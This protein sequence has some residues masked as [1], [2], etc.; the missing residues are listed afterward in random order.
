MGLRPKSRQGILPW[1]PW[2]GG[3]VTLL[4]AAP[5]GAASYAIGQ[6]GAGAEGV[7]GAATA[8]QDLPEV[9]WFNPAAQP[10]GLVLSIGAS[11]IFPRVEHTA[12][13]GT[14]T[15]SESAP[16]TPPWAHLGYVLQHDEQRFG[17]FVTGHVP[18]GAGLQWPETWTGRFEVTAVSLRVYEAAANAVY[19]ITLNDDV[20]LGVGGLQ[21]LFGVAGRSVLGGLRHLERFGA[22]RLGPGAIGLLGLVGVGAGA[23]GGVE[24]VRYP[25]VACLH[26]AAD[27]AEHPPADHE[28]D[29]TEGDDQPEQL[30][31]EGGVNLG[32]LRHLALRPLLSLL[33]DEKQDH[34][35][36][37]RQ[38]AEKLGCGEADEQA[39]LLAIGGGRIAKRALEERA[40]HVTN[41]QCGHAHA[42]RGETSTQQFCCF[43]VHD[44][45]SFC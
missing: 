39:A 26:G 16:A 34:G 30:R 35:D 23:L 22:V 36:D 41:A 37:E 32:N 15:G 11:A 21:L 10:A 5:A 7:A 20:E 31:R 2:L 1:T 8:R 42:D 44:E 29:Q 3:L 43:C 45:N 27:L 14:V 38:Q 12:P 33:G 25:L 17:L 28:I 40:K 6:Q 19:G 4:M 13:G 18:F 24:I 9:G